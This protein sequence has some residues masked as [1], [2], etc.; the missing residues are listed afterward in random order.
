MAK[1]CSSRPVELIFA[2]FK[3][4]AVVSDRFFL[5]FSFL[6]NVSRKQQLAYLTFSSVFLSYA[7]SSQNSKLHF[8]SDAARLLFQQDKKNAIVSDVIYLSKT[9]Q[10]DLKTV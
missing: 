9:I 7:V 4:S 6:M 8:I 1:N 3:V 2:D 10:E 5:R